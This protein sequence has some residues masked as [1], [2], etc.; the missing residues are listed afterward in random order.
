MKAW[1]IHQYG[2]SSEVQLLDCPRP[3]LSSHQSN[4]E[5]II[6]VKAASIPLVGLTSYQ[7]LIECGKIGP[8]SKVFIPA[9]SGGV[10]SFAI[11]LAK[12]FGAYVCTN[13]S[14][15]NSDFV[16]NLGANEVLDYRT[17]DFSKILKDYDFVF[18]TMGGETQR[19]AFSILKRGGKLVSIV[20]P[21]TL[22]FA[23]SASLS[24]PV[25]FFVGLL[26]LPTHFRA[27]LR[28]AQYS[29]LFMKADGEALS[30]IGGLIEQKAI[31]PVIDRVLPFQ[32]ADE[33]LQYVEK[34]HAR[35]KVVVSLE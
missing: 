19:K 16:R 4:D 13:T 8:F 18:D 29:F 15:K 22:E 26:S 12:H 21:P 3:T 14:A 28:R 23:R 17:T 20:G 27:F 5:V 10:G 34:G 7:A 6:E 33:A 2:D 31:Q 35:G 32:Q 25:R 24:L 1:A 30:L 9:G 11:Q